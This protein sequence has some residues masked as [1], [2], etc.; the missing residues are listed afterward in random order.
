MKKKLL[1][2]VLLGLGVSAQSVMAEGLNYNVVSI[3][4]QVSKEVVRDTLNV[5]LSVREEGRDP[6]VIAQ[7]VTKKMNQVL[8]QAKAYPKVEVAVSGRSS[9]PSNNKKDQTIWYDQATISLK[10][11]D[12][13][14]LNKLIATVQGQAQIQNMHY[15]VS[16]KKM[17]SFEEDL[18]TT[19][20]ERFRYKAN[21]IAKGLGGKGYRIVNIDMGSTPASYNAG[22]APKMMRAAAPAMD[23]MAVMDAEPGNEQVSLSISGQVQVNGL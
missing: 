7:A 19:A 5:R 11:Q 14:A 6:A 12:F 9:Y 10:S 20:I 2:P 1:V 23:E 15:S 18:M 13:Q 3:N 4:E 16:D 8:A 21:H 22:Y 17:K